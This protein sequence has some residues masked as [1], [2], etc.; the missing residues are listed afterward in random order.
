MS[1]FG[2]VHD[3]WPGAWSWDLLAPELV[4]RGHTAAAM[5]LPCEDHDATFS[6]YAAAVDDALGAAG[7]PVPA[8]SRCRGIVRA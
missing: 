8:G 7:R 3:A 6:D 5:D 4:R 2:L 1:T